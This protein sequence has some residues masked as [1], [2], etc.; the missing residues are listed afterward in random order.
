VGAKNFDLVF[1]SFFVG[2]VFELKFE[3]FEENVP[4]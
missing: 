3:K 1:F 4:N 2:F